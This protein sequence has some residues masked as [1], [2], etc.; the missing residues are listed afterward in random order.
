MKFQARI[1]IVPPS[2]MAPTHL[3]E[4]EDASQLCCRQQ[5]AFWD[6]NW[7][8]SWLI[9][10]PVFLKNSSHQSLLRGRLMEGGGHLNSEAVLTGVSTQVPRWPGSV[11]FSADPRENERA[12]RPDEEPAGSLLSL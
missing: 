10:K 5:T 12:S 7:N 6:T 1:L 8:R 9:I 3:N 11:D 4:D 2:P